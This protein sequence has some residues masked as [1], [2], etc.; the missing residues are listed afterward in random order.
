MNQLPLVRLGSTHT[1]KSTVTSSSPDSRLLGSV[2]ALPLLLAPPLKVKPSPAFHVAAPATVPLRPLPDESAA[3]VPEVSSS[4]HQPT[5]S[6]A[7]SPS[8]PDAGPTPLT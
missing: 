4:F 6:V 8:T 1:S 3:T 7:R 2:M 5:R